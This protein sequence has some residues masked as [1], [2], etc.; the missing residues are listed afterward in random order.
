VPRFEQL[1]EGPDRRERINVILARLV[2]IGW[3]SSFLI[4]D[5]Q[6]SFSVEWTDKGK[7]RARQVIDIVTEFRGGPEDL[8]ALAVICRLQPPTESGI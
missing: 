5:T 3:L 7:E 4:H 6:D 2:Q 8:M 1:F